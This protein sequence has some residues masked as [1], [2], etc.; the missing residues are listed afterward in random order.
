V[1]S[2]ADGFLPY[3]TEYAELPHCHTVFKTAK[4]TWQQT[5]LRA[6]AMM[7]PNCAFDS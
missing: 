6:L 3:A 5:S 2:G 4:T 7:T 1:H